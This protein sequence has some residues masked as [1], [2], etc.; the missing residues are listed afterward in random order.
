[1]KYNLSCPS[2]CHL[3]IC[4]VLYSFTIYVTF[5]VSFPSSHI[6][7]SRRNLYDQF[8]SERTAFYSISRLEVGLV[9][10]GPTGT[11]SRKVMEHPLPFLNSKIQNFLVTAQTSSPYQTYTK[12][13]RYWVRLQINGHTDVIFHLGSPSTK[14]VPSPR[15]YLGSTCLIT[16][17]NHHSL[18]NERAFT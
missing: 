8:L 4:N 15:E 17:R 5:L 9:E 6:L 3:L 11:S 2:I 1:M 7:V 16:G 13:R 14:V 18:K 12:Q 10:P